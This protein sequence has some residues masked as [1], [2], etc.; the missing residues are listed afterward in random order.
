MFGRRGS[1]RNEDG[2][3]REDG[4]GRG[5]PNAVVEAARQVD[6]GKVATYHSDVP[7]GAP[8]TR[9]SDAPRR[10]DGESKRLVVGRDTILSGG[11]VV[12]CDLLIVEGLVEAA[13]PRGS[14]LDIVK[15]GSFLG[16]ATVDNA[17]IS[18]SFE[19]E[20]TVRKKLLIRSTGC[21]SGTTRYSR[22]EIERGGRLEGQTEHVPATREAGL[23]PLAIPAA[24]DAQAASQEDAAKG[25]EHSVESPLG[26][27]AE[28]GS[29]IRT[30]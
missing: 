26:F 6:P 23:E 16:A 27:F 22:L 14:L 15:G 20:L 8:D 3:D 29:R 12:D 9:L 28:A 4:E 25:Q 5:A 1:D 30:N 7:R 11:V 17:D 10:V 19:G 2:Q 24:E 13:M 18:G 21:V